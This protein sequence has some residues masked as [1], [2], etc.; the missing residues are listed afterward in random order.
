MN[1]VDYQATSNNNKILILE[2]RRIVVSNTL[3]CKCVW[4]MLS[5]EEIQDIID[6]TKKKDLAD[7]IY[8]SQRVKFVITDLLP[9]VTIII[10]G[11]ILYFTFN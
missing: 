5:K 4:M 10:M 1:N 3:D 11:I 7:T 2:D 9:A 6:R 8:Y